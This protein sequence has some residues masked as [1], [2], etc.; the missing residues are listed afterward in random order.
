ML[1]N[2]HPETV[3]DITEEGRFHLQC[4]KV[5]IPSTTFLPWENKF[6]L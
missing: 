6:G 4:L 5:W 1:G 3:C 2:K